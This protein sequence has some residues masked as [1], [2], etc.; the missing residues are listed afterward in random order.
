MTTDLRDVTAAEAARITG[1]SPAFMK[2]HWD[3]I[4][5]AFRE[6]SRWIVSLAGLRA[7]QTERATKGGKG[8]GMEGGV[9]TSAPLSNLAGNK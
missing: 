2:R 3:E 5:T 1:H 7:W 9:S 4:P 8:G 6:G